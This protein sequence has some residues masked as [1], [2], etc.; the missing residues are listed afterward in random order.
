MTDM[1]SVVVRAIHETRRQYAVE[2][3]PADPTKAYGPP[4]QAPWFVIDVSK[5]EPAVNWPGELIAEYDDPQKARDH[6]E[7]LVAKAAIETHEKALEEQGLVIGL[8]E[9]VAYSNKTPAG[10]AIWNSAIEAAAEWLANEDIEN[11]P[12]DLYTG[13]T[14]RVAAI[15]KLKKP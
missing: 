15:R 11:D 5:A 8:R 1:L 14:H 3:T 12:D 13:R 6:L 9:P 7:S 4:W 2:G 10:R